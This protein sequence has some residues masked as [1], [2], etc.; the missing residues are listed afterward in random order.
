[1]STL[2][3]S[4]D[5]NRKVAQDLAV[6]RL[7]RHPF[8]LDL[9]N[10][11]EEITCHLITQ[12]IFEQLWNSKLPSRARTSIKKWMVENGYGFEFEKNGINPLTIID[13]LAGLKHTLA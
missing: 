11:E 13:N 10:E 12:K 6:G 7:I 5:F 1:M 8:K 9:S 4:D 2:N 3:P